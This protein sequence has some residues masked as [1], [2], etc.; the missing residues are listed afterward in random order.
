V[1]WLANG[2]NVTITDTGLTGDIWSAGF[3]WINLSP[4][5]GGITNSGGT[6]S[7]FACG[8]ITARSSMRRAKPPRRRTTSGCFPSPPPR[9]R[10]AHSCL[11]KAALIGRFSSLLD[12]SFM[13]QL[14]MTP[15]LRRWL[16][17]NHNMLS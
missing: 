4:T 15:I 12:L 10:K 9:R 3:G 2:G 13:R 16:S 6:L 8:T 14:T 17:V 5:N 11:P 7:G 1:N